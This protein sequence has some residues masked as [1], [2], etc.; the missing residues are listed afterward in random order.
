M[1]VGFLPLPITPIFWIHHILQPF[2]MFPFTHTPFFCYPQLFWPFPNF[3][4]SSQN[5]GCSERRC[6]HAPNFFLL[7]KVFATALPPPQTSN[8]RA[9]ILLQTLKNG[10]YWL[11]W[12]SCRQES[13]AGFHEYKKSV[14]CDLPCCMF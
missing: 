7:P 5:F 12:H 11:F 3:F 14:L 2:K 8:I 13:T 9:V 10:A 6:C 1:N 4:T